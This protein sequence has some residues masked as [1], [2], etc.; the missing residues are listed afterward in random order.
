MFLQ[1]CEIAKRT[2]GGLYWNIN[3]IPITQKTP[4]LCRTEFSYKLDC[5]G[6]ESFDVF[7]V[8]LSR[9]GV[10]ITSSKVQIL[11]GLSYSLYVAAHDAMHPELAT[12]KA[13]PQEDVLSRPSSL[14]RD[15]PHLA[16][17]FIDHPIPARR[18]R[19]T[20]GPSED[21]SSYLYPIELLPRRSKTV[22]LDDI[23][24]LRHLA[25]GCHS[26]VYS[27]YLDGERVAVK[28]IR[29]DCLED[30][31]ALNEFAAEEQ[32]LSRTNHPNVIKLIGTG[33]N[34]RTFLVFE[35]LGGGILGSILSA[36]KLRPNAMKMFHRNTFS[37]NKVL[38]RALEFASAMRYLHS[39]VAEDVTIIHRDLKPDNIG[40]SATGELKVADF[41][42]SIC[43]LRRRSL[44]QTYAMSGNTGSLRYMAPEV[45]SNEKYSETVDVYSYGIILW[46]M[47]TDMVPFADLRT[48]NFHDEVVVKRLRPK[49]NT[50]SWPPAFCSLLESCW[51]PIPTRRPT[52]SEICN[53][54]Q[55]LILGIGNKP[56]SFMANLV[57]RNSA[58]FK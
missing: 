28:F 44:D 57:K 21:S 39:E 43:V 10:P 31:V 7:V 36:N 16:L 46:Q 4:L 40:F 42:M 47:A 32:I 54:L 34:P 30:H 13:G 17:S 35:W 56:E 14:D 19:S 2:S 1:L 3:S 20:K 27:G 50:K 29:E 5:P 53:S 25:E 12:P 52:F 45:A 55:V 33:S 24:N 51:D 58:R 48:A 23:K 49:I 22:D 38:T 9:M 8:G 11:S 26:S 37:F 6:E 18:V 41:G 15:D